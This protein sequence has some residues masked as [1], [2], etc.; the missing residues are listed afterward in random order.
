MDFDSLLRSLSGGSNT[1]STSKEENQSDL[2]ELLGS[3]LGGEGQD[4]KPDLSVLAGLLQP[5]AEADKEKE[6]PSE[7]VIEKLKSIAALLKSTGIDD[8]VS[9]FL[10]ERFNLPEATVN[11]LIGGLAGKKQPAKRKKSAEPAKTARRKSTKSTK[12]S[13]PT[14]ARK[15][16]TTQNDKKPARKKTT[17]QK[18]SASEKKKTTRSTTSRSSS[19][20]KSTTTKRKTRSSE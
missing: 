6:E 8:T 10:A 19:S 12:K 17:A 16:T 3:M 2:A 13:S 11:D 18:S 7:D 14:A 20:S 1:D 5:Q 4:A 9:K 15:K